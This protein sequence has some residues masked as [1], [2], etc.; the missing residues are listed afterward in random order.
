[1]PWFYS[2]LPRA[3]YIFVRLHSR[4]PM[5]QGCW[6]YYCN[7]RWIMY[8]YCH[9]FLSELQWHLISSGV[10]LRLFFF[11]VVVTGAFHV[12]DHNFHVVRG[13]GCCSQG[14]AIPKV[15]EHAWIRQ[16]SC[17]QHCWHHWANQKEWALSILS[18]NEMLLFLLCA[19]YATTVAMS[20][21]KQKRKMMLKRHQKLLHDRSIKLYDK[22]PHKR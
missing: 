2:S 8:C 7:I 13:A 9:C 6:W 12:L 14:S 15:A 16:A 20:E 5:D 4:F 11:F 3:S 17:R 10:C 18:V 22:P 19:D 21:I 1:M